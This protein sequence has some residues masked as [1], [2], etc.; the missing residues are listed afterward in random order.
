[1]IFVG[2]VDRAGRHRAGPVSMIRG[3]H[4][5]VRRARA[6]AGSIGLI[7]LLVVGLAG[8]ASA[9]SITPVKPVERP[10][11]QPVQKGARVPLAR[12]SAGQIKARADASLKG[13]TSVRV[14]TVLPDFTVDVTVT[15]DAAYLQN[16]QR[17]QGTEH[18][19][20]VG[21]R[22]WYTGDATFYVTVIGL[23]PE[24]ARTRA[25]H[26]DEVPPGIEAP[27]ADWL[28]L[29]YWVKDFRSITVSQKR[30]G[31]LCGGRRTVG[32]GVPRGLTIY[33]AA[34]G[35]PYPLAIENTYGHYWLQY[36][37]W[38]KKVRITAPAA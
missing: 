9:V 12:L 2:W 28:Q 27:F 35:R 24:E 30:P 19:V 11:A 15:K 21:N 17:T 7:A 3:F 38:N 10:K 14:R 18:V 32:V 20:R 33:V 8:P 34:S 29:D 13:V 6:T 22:T 4:M 5:F 25:G 37:N 36:S 1:M 16:T 26:W 31:K 23:S